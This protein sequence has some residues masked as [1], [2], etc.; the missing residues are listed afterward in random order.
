[1]EQTPRSSVGKDRVDNTVDG[2][3]ESSSGQSNDQTVEYDVQTVERV[4]R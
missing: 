3:A 4:Y 1:M 2:A